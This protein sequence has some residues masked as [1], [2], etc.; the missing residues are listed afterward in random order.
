MARF[1]L[2]MCVLVL[3]LFCLSGAEESQEESREKR[4]VP[5]WALTSSDFFGWIEELRNHAGYDKIDELAR[6]FW[7]HF[8]S[9]SRLG[10]DS[11]APEE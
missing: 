6:T 11:P 5:N 2:A 1:S 9:A 4:D 7:A 3:G 8:P 10:Y